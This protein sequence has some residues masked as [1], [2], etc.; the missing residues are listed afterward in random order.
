MEVAFEFD[1]SMQR[2]SRVDGHHAVAFGGKHVHPQVAHAF[3][4][5][6]HKLHLGS[7]V[8]IQHSRV[9]LIWVKAARLEEHRVQ[10]LARFELMGQ[11]FW[12]V[13]I[14]IWN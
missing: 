5:V 11:N 8:D 2:S 6:G 4:G 1:S 9:L 10:S 12:T 13:A 14:D 7:S 3:E